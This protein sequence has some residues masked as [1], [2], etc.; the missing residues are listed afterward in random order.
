[1]PAAATSTTS[2]RRDADPRPH[3][4]RGGGDPRG[5]RPDVELELLAGEG[6]TIET[7]SPHRTRGARHADGRQPRRPRVRPGRRRRAAADVP[8]RRPRSRDR[9]HRQPHRS[10]RR[11][12]RGRR[13]RRP[14][15]PGPRPTT[16]PTTPSRATPR[17]TG[18]SPAS[19]PPVPASRRWRTTGSGDF[20]EAAV[21]ADL[22]R[23]AH[24]QV[25]RPDLE[26]RAL[27]A[28]LEDEAQRFAPRCRRWPQGGPLHERERARSRD[29]SAARCARTLAREEEASAPG[30]AASRPGARSTSTSKGR[31]DKPPV[32]LGVP[33]WSKPTQLHLVRQVITR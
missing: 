13:R 22:D 7:I 8:V 26:L 14:P 33:R 10:R 3:R 27:V 11:V 2:P 30:H 12:R 21:V 25:R 15:R 18:R 1:M 9:A 29:V 31:K 6:V 16:P 24:P 28:E 20:G 23:E 5:R 17:S 19:S 32:L 4:E